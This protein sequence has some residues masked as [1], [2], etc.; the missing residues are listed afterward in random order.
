MSIVDATS[1]QMVTIESVDQLAN[2]AIIMKA[3]G[4]DKVTK[5]IAKA[6]FAKQLI[7]HNMIQAKVKGWHSLQGQGLQTATPKFWNNLLASM[8]TRVC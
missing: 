7:V 5:D 1:L 6:A 3:P 4:V 2:Y 8:K